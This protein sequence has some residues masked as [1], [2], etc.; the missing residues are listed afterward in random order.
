MEFVTK[1]N[2]ENKMGMRIMINRIITNWR[3]EKLKL[4]VVSLSIFLRSKT[5]FNT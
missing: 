1:Q 4:K 2:I 5:F 3:M